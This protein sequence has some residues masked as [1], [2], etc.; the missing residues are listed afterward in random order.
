MTSPPPECEPIEIVTELNNPFFPRAESSLKSK[1]ERISFIGTL[2]SV[3]QKP[4]LETVESSLAIYDY[5]YDSVDDSE[6]LKNFQEQQI[7]TS[8]PK[9][10]ISHNDCSENRSKIRALNGWGF[11]L[12]D[13]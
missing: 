8:F 2:P 13:K 3:F 10:E 4:S 6:L 7:I 11:V 1:E 12:P 5:L 9:A